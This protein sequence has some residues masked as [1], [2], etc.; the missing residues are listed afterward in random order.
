M[1][2]DKKS[3]GDLLRF[4]VLDDVAKPVRL[5]GPDPTLLAAAYAEISKEPP[6]GAPG[7][8]VQLGL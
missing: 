7:V 2:R 3:R 5:E 4:V 6:T 8:P 1:R